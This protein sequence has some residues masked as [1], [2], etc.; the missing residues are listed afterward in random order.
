M[1]AA[2]IASTEFSDFRF[3]RD[4]DLPD[5]GGAASRFK[6]NVAA[7]ALLKRLEA[8][9]RP[10]GD[11]TMEE[12]RTLARYTGW[13]DSD[14]LNRAFPNGTYSWS[15][16]YTELQE[17][18]T[19]DEIKSL[20]ASTLNAHFTSLP[21]IGA[22]Y[23]ALDHFGL[24]PHGGERVLELDSGQSVALGLSGQ[25]KLRIIEP[26]AGVGHFLG[27]MPQS[28][29]ANSERVAVE[30]DS[31]TGRILA[32]LYPQAKVF[33]Q[34][35]EETPL[36]ENYFDLVASNVPFGAYQ[37]ADAS[38]RES[39]L[40]ASIH[41]YFFVRSLRLVKPGGVI[42]F[43]TSRYTLDKKSPKV[44]LHLATHAEL[45][46]AARLPRNA[47]RANAGTQVVTDVLIFRKRSQPCR[48]PQAEWI[49][50]GEI[51]LSDGDGEEREISV[52]NL[53]TAHPERMLGRPAFG[54]GMYEAE[55]FLLHDDGRDLAES[56]AETLIAQLPADGYRAFAASAVVEETITA[57]DRD[58]FLAAANSG[59]LSEPDRVC[60]NQLLEIYIAAKEVI[61]LQL[62]DASDEELKAKQRELS[63]LYS[64]FR[65][66]FGYINKNI[67]K[68]SPHSPVVPFLKALEIPVGK[69]LYNR[70][71][72]FS[73]R[74]IRPAR[75]QAGRCEPKEALLIS[76]ND[77]GRVDLDYIVRLCQRSHS[78][79]LAELGALIYETPSGEYVTA[80][81][82]LSGDV[83]QKL[84]EAELAAQI[85]PAFARNVEALRSVQPADLGRD[86]IIVRLGS[87]WVPETFVRDFISSLV[88]SFRGSVKYISALAVWKIEN[89]SA[90]SR[91]SVEATQT[92][93][94]SRANAFE[95]I[96]DILNLRTTTVTDEIQGPDG[97]VRRVVNDNETIAAQAK[98]LEIK[99]QFSNW[100]WQDESRSATLIRIYNERFNAFRK[101]EYDGGHLSLPGMSA[102]ITLY[103]HQ[104]NAIWRCLQE[105]AT[106]LAHCVGA[107]KTFTMI[108]AAM[109]LKR[110]GLCHKSLIVVPNHLPAQWA[111]EAIRLYPNIRLLAPEK[112]HLTSSQRGELLS[113][114]ATSEFDA[115][116]LPMT[117]FK[118]LPLNPETVRDYIQREI[119]TLTEYL[120]ELESA[121]G[122]SKRSHKEI[123]RA[124]K[125]L[126]ARLDDTNQK[127]KRV[128]ADT[129]T[130]DELGID[131]LYIDEFH[132]FKNLYCPTKMSRVAGLPNV[133]SQRAF[134]CFMKVRSVL[135]NGGRVVCAT[136]TP[137]SNT[138]A[139]VYVCQKFLQLE[140]LQELGLDHFDAWVQ[141]F[142]ETTQSLEMTPDG[143]SF[144]MRSRF[145]RFTNIP[146]LSKL[147]QQVLDVKPASEL[148][149]PRPKLKG[150]RPEI[151]SVPASDELKEYVRELARRVEAIKARRVAP[152]VDNMLKVTS[153]GRKAAL[154]IRLV[155]PDAPRPAQSKVMAIV[156]NIARLY[157][158]TQDSCGVQI[159][160]LDIGVSK[161]KRCG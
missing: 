29:K 46:A 143:A 18:L 15:C 79:A 19:P 34:P 76:L 140:M 56:L 84:R 25:P 48:E 55:E 92:W 5:L 53:Y 83:R 51:T 75:R 133:D 11:L 101:R 85:N 47:F 105:K 132:C 23:A 20:L 24:A 161:M 22:I 36:P 111:A 6:C 52:N 147:W 139:E 9:S 98:Q 60:I 97:G 110:L 69:N 142:A 107:G 113:R 70:A 4:D 38:I 138:I 66:R 154:D 146:E 124:I 14:V 13:G 151:I 86:E 104:A 117:A 37:I 131:A 65:M 7:I 112:E 148:N 40:K 103:Q 77:K 73:E 153:D 71:P 150:G 145:N 90:W 109:E 122:K 95:L 94:T 62:Q 128:S 30:I 41:D 106:L 81:E 42:A 31:L 121:G 159:L 144:Q 3:D 57:S 33:I 134:D 80:E 17:L 119:D 135:E 43:I 100:I 16:P 35:F 72:L 158:E 39:A 63:D 10:H 149:L 102:D 141:Q 96:E 156:E 118:M 44:R 126:K 74:T 8:E 127:I 21:I 155:K 78:E 64:G 136:A 114:I 152:H 32:R 67:K 160:F 27:A 115:I 12:R 129:I 54:R 82:Y 28:L 125:K 45:L 61:R 108:A 68:L 58:D 137:I 123:Q 87:A 89:V 99:Q 59:E 130:W 2:S 120:E 26:A 50:V 88:P 93:G 157:H 91:S 116:I 1:Q 49:D